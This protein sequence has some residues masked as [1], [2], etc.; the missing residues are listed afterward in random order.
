MNMIY[1]VA[2][3]E[4]EEGTGSCAGTKYTQ[5]CML[6]PAV[7]DY[8][9]EIQAFNDSH[10]QPSMRLAVDGQKINNSTFRD[11]NTTLKQQNNFNIHETHT[12]V[13][14][15]S[16]TRL[17]GI[18]QGLNTYLGG[19]AS[20]YYD[21]IAG[22]QLDQTGNAPVYL[23]N[24]LGTQEGKTQSK[25][26][27]GFKYNNPMEPQTFKDNAA[28]DPAHHYDVP[29]IVGKINQIMF[30]TARDISNED[31]DKDT[32]AGTLSRPATVYRDTIHYV[33]HFGYMWGAFA[34]MISCILFVLPVYY[35]YWQLG[36]EVTLGPFEIAAAFRAPNL[37]HESNA[38]IDKV[39]KE[40]GDRQVKFGQIVTGGD[41]GKI[42]VAEAEV[43]ARIHPSA[44]V[45][46]SL[47]SWRASRHGGTSAT[48]APPGR[49]Q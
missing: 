35:G 33:T 48:T 12:T 4:S 13:S 11:F 18:A 7:I 8:P 5:T 46:K 45:G 16:R 42:A 29:S 37:Y 28:A 43:V 24:D 27:C 32:A 36:R 22:F 3:D 25:N 6:R 9:V 30:A 15:D 1:T 20:I 38:P 34:S 49:A 23:A 44:S 47:Q 39:I 17:G 21:A 41:A 26:L 31:D 10:T 19:N 2:E 14:D 40:V